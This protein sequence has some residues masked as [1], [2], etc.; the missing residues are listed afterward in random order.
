MP[1]GRTLARQ[2]GGTE[3]LRL[4]NAGD[5]AF[6]AQLNTGDLGLYVA[7]CGSLRLVAGTGTVMP[8]A[9]TI[10]AV[11]APGGGSMN[12]ARCSSRRR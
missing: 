1:G 7:W 9:G 4:N 8:G 10:T 5:V 6:V 11:R 3:E 2:L 12:V